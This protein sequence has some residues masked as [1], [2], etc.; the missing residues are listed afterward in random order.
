MAAPASPTLSAP[1]LATLAALGEERTAKLGNVLYRVGDTS[2]PFVA[3]LEGEVAI[4]DGRRRSRGNGRP[5][6]DTL[7]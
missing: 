1:Q 4:Q 6:F 2:Y 7:S 5:T 3:I